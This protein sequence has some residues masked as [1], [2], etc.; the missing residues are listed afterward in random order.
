[1]IA[2]AIALMAQEQ[3]E[4]ITG[5]SYVNDVYYNLENGIDTTVAREN[6]DIAFTVQPIKYN[7]TILI[8][9]AAGVEL[10]T[11][12]LGDTADW[13]TLD[14]TGMEWSPM[15]NS[16]ETLEEGAF[17]THATEHPD[18]GWGI[19]NDLSHM[20]AGDSLFVIKTVSGTY[21]KLAIIKM[22][23][24]PMANTWEFKY[25]NLDSTDEQS[26]LLNSGEYETKSFVYYSLDNDETL[27]R[28]PPSADWDMLFTKYTD[29]IEYT[30]ASDVS[31]I[32][33]NEDHIVVQEVRE[34]ALDQ[35]TFVSFEDTAFSPEIGIIGYDWKRLNYQ[36]F[37]FELIDTVV[38]F[39]KKY[40]ET[41]SNGMKAA[42]TDSTYYKIYF[43]DFTG[44]SEGK[45]TFIQEKLSAVST[46]NPGMIQMFQVYPNPASEYVNVVFDYTGETGIQII[47]MTGRTVHSIVHNAGGFTSLSLDIARLEPG[48]FFLKVNTGNETGV[49]RFIK[50]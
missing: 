50:E 37:S 38:Y 17:S 10:Y 46:G 35:S 23:P 41:E 18:Y 40:T 48:L 30:P 25:A 39:I 15:Y 44:M 16:L 24:N 2:A 13:E 4:V 28:E 32:L 33:T 21:K 43:T 47:D 45:Y 7:V 27:D 31:G 9:S 42:G 5:A 6:W 19:Y 34:T 8:N 3:I 26:V 12:P 49:L 11:Y 14:T 1:M 20:I 22:N 36:T 29:Y